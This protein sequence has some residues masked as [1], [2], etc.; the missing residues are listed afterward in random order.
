MAAGD[1]VGEIQT[2]G[3]ADGV[4]LPHQPAKNSSRRTLPGSGWMPA[5][6]DLEDCE[7]GLLVE[8]YNLSREGIGLSD[9]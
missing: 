5:G 6:A 9:M 7:V 1:G 2:T 8:T 3:G 4:R